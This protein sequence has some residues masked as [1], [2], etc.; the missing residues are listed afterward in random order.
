MEHDRANLSR[1]RRHPP[2]SLTR[3]I[4]GWI[5]LSLGVLGLAVPVLPGL[6]LLGL[7]MLILGPRDPAL[8]RATVQ[9]RLALRHW[10]RAR[11]PRLRQ[12][13]RWVRQ[14]HRAARATLRSHLHDYMHGRMSWTAHLLMLA[15]S[16]IGMAV[17]ATTVFMI[18]RA[19]SLG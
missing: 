6:L 13:G 11:H 3:R 15:V 2:R 9:I 17:T 5:V 12:I 7:G 18:W 4:V 8:R 19:I 1:R 10:S 16:L 14:R